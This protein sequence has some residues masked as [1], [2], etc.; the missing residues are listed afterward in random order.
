MK[1]MRVEY[2]DG[3]TDI[4]VRHFGNGETVTAASFAQ[5]FQMQG[6]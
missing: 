3:D 4:L 2:R 5:V 6:I 1:E